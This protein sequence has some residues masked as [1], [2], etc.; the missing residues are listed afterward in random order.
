MNKK[1]KKKLNDIILEEVIKTSL[2]E[3]SPGDPMYVMPS[4][5]LRVDPSALAPK[6]DPFKSTAP[7]PDIM[8]DPAI[9]PRSSPSLKQTQTSYQRARASFIKAHPELKR[10]E[11]ESAEQHKDRMEGINPITRTLIRGSNVT[12]K[13]FNLNLQSEKKWKEAKDKS[14]GKYAKNY[15]N[16]INGIHPYKYK[17]ATINSLIKNFGAL[18]FL[19][20]KIPPKFMNTEWGEIAQK[21]GE[22]KFGEYL[23][24]NYEVGAQ[25]AVYGASPLGTYIYFFK[26]GQ[27]AMVERPGSGG[28]P[29]F[30][31]EWKFHKGKIKLFDGETEYGTLSYSSTR[32]EIIWNATSIGQWEAQLQISID[33]EWNKYLKKIPILNTYGQ[34]RVRDKWGWAGTAL[35]YAQM[36]GDW[37][38]IVYPV[39]DVVNGFI[40]LVKGRTFEACLS[41]IAIVPVF[42]DAGSVI[43][44]AAYRR[45]GKA[46]DALMAGFRS[47][48]VPLDDAL[49]I[50]QFVRGKIPAIKSFDRYGV[51]PPE[52]YK[53]IKAILNELEEKLIKGSSLSKQEISD[54][55]ARMY[56][57]NPDK[58]HNIVKLGI[59]GMDAPLKITEAI[60]KSLLYK[61]G[62]L[63]VK[64]T[65][66]P[67]RLIAT[68]G[69]YSKTQVTEGIIRG[70]KHF[71]EQCV[72]QPKYCALV[73]DAFIDRNT[74]KAVIGTLL[75]EMKAAKVPGILGETI[76]VHGKKIKPKPATI[77]I[78]EKNILA[79]V[80]GFKRHNPA[81]FKKW[82]NGGL[83]K[84]IGGM[85][86]ASLEGVNL[87]Y[88]T[89]VHS[90]R[91]RILG[92]I[93]P[94]SQ[95]IKNPTVNKY[96]KQIVQRTTSNS[97]GH[98][99]NWPQFKKALPVIYNEVLEYHDWKQGPQYY[100]DP[101]TGE[102]KLEKSNSEQSV[103]LMLINEVCNA[104]GFD[105]AKWVRE[106]K[107]LTDQLNVGQQ[108]ENLMRKTEIGFVAYD[109]QPMDSTVFQSTFND[110]IVKYHPYTEN[111]EF[112]EQFRD[113]YKNADDD[114]RK[115]MMNWKW[116][117]ISNWAKIGLIEPYVT[118]GQIKLDGD[119]VYKIWKV[120][121]GT[122]QLTQYGLKANDYIDVSEFYPRGGDK[123]AY[124]QAYI[125]IKQRGGFKNDKGVKQWRD[126]E[127]EQHGA[128][129]RKIPGT[130]V[131]QKN[132]FGGQKQKK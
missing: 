55:I 16:D 114:T 52:Q 7:A 129:F 96:T 13:A 26:G 38:G 53:E 90:V 82:V 19:C 128:P 108:A 24:T 25:L 116:A 131:Y 14:K 34:T 94:V 60:T 65:T 75:R 58:L 31:C 73:I 132:P 41:F 83:K 50:L 40:Y 8:Y 84:W 1:S 92:F 46:A 3:Q 21:F 117:T 51:I 109:E 49:N 85:G 107:S 95:S 124:E 61:G 23:N 29:Q 104:A 111:S 102:I 112:R 88:S 70:H 86:E 15:P 74:K 56:L 12:D 89:V 103:A 71:F 9:G 72:K 93:S 79:Y 22:K 69:Q 28:S 11:D 18:P 81:A 67:L 97:K 64:F 127:Q 119:D 63:I 5:T 27:C 120:T 113:D 10:K 2:F 78:I 44:K 123:A 99:I 33:P 122:V 105:L 118:G 54:K 36:A 48:K 43:A 20:N 30:G 6:I 125:K 35:D 110:I 115:A 106:G 130:N 98:I 100:K 91:Y 32:R 87:L 45:T 4:S 68:L 66:Y 47:V 57:K 126:G 42:G 101:T 59:G 62:K 121:K 80:E 39:V 77:E 17:D 37:V 76:T